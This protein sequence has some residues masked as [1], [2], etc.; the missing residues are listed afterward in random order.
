M[1]DRREAPE[2]AASEAA[3]RPVAVALIGAGAIGGFHGESLARRVPG[4][5]LAAVVDPAPGA[6]ERLAARLGAPVAGTDPAPVLADPDL[7][8]VLVA[9]PARAHTDLVVKSAQAGKAV[10]VEKPMALTLADADRAITACRE[11]GVVLQVGFNRRFDRGWEDARALVD[12]GALGTPH[13][14]RSLTRDPATG[15]TD[16]P[17]PPAWT[18]FFETLIHDID[19]LRYLNPGATVTSVHAIADALVWPAGKADGL[20][21]TAVVTVRFDNGAIGTAEASFSAAY[22][23]DVRGEV[24]GPGGMASMGD[25]RR[26]S[27]TFSGAAG[28]TQ[29]TQRRNTDLFHEAYVAQLAHFAACVRTGAEPRA[30][31]GD[32]RAALAVALAC[33]RSVEQGRPVAPVE[34]PGEG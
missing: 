27:M 31:G 23:Y 24:F 10:F 5:R 17:H 20:L 22:G 33:I 28:R 18:I 19:A 12:A 7:E 34:H 8:A 3:A 21:D 14:L 11:A 15:A 26:S 30:T 32:A 1:S 16:P 6:A 2:G 9:A 4:T 13:L 25:I 29:E